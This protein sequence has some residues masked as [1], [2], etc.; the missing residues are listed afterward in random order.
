MSIGAEEDCRGT[1]MHAEPL[2]S[3]VRVH[4]AGFTNVGWG[5]R[6]V[7]RY[8]SKLPTPQVIG[9]LLMPHGGPDPL[10]DMGASLQHVRGG[11]PTPQTLV[12]DIRGRYALIGGRS[13]LLDLTH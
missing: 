5:G 11:R 12:D 13:P 3:S 10:D 9:F 7:E 2:H 4:G 6:F 8:S 1:R